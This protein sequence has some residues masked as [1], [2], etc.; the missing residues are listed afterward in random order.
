MFVCCCVVIPRTGTGTT[1][2]GTKRG[3]DRSNKT[4]NDLALDVAT[5]SGNRAL[6]KTKDKAQE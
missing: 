5:N 4:E 6:G 3:R 1:S 2:T